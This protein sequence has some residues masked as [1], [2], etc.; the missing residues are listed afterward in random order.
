MN[1]EID[2]AEFNTILAALRLYQQ[3]DFVSDEIWA[4]AQLDGGPLALDNDEIDGLCGRLNFTETPSEPESSRYSVKVWRETRCHETGTAIVTATSEEEALE[5]ACSEASW[6][7]YTYDS[8]TVEDVLDN[9]L[10]P[11]YQDRPQVRLCD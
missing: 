4:I 5:K 6:L 1:I 11:D 3:T 7:D 9:G 2:H 8:D 10:E